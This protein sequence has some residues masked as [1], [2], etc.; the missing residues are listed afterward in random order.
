MRKVLGKN[1]FE[2]STLVV[3]RELLGKYIVWRIRGKEFALLVTEVEAYDGFRDKASHAH[4]GMTKRNA[5]MFGEAG[6]L[7]VYL[8]YGIHEMLNIVVGKNDYPAAILIRGVGDIR[9][10]GR[11]SKALK[12]ERGL[13]GKKAAKES[14]IWFEDRGEKVSMR[15]ISR[16][17]RVGVSYA[18]EHWA[19]KQYRFTL[20]GFNERTEGR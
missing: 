7:Y 3:A 1:F 18:G 12:V 4:R 11:V 2:R 8:C 20:R 13:N 16:S 6:Y 17:A 5:V 9:G 19:S 14:G 15:R 10:P